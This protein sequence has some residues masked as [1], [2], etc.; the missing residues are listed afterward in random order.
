MVLTAGA[1]ALLKKGAQ[2]ASVA[3]GKKLVQ[4]GIAPKAA[5]A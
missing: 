4:K 2:R 1:G 3:V 5:A